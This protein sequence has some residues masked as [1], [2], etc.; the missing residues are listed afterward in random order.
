DEAFAGIDE[1]M[2]GKLMGLTVAFDLDVILTGH[3]LWGAYGEVPSVAVHDLLR[4]PPAEGVSVV[5]LR[6]DGHDLIEDENLAGTAAGSVPQRPPSEGL[7]AADS[8][9]P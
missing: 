6:W 7:F 5:S 1:E 2:R 3:E 8:N 9:R 4:R